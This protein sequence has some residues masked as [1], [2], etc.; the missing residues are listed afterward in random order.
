M[1]EKILYFDCEC[2]L[3]C[4]V[5]VWGMGVYGYFEMY[6]K[7]GDVFVEKYICVKVFLGVGK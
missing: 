4:V 1:I 6:G 5:Y 2:I 7:F 3:E